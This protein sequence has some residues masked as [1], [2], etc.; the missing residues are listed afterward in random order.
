MPTETNYKT[1]LPLYTKIRLQ[2]IDS[3]CYLLTNQQLPTQCFLC[4]TKMFSLLC[5]LQICKLK[6][7]KLHTC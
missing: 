2:I 3:L 4:V 6:L 1:N 7:S 5:N